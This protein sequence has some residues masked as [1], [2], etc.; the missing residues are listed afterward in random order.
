[1]GSADALPALATRPRFI[2][3]TDFDGTITQQ[4]SNDFLADHL[5]YGAER[6][7]Q[8]FNADVLEGR[9]HFRDAFHEMM[10]SIA[11]P[12]DA[13][14]ALLLDN[15]ALDPHFA[16]FYA[17]ARAAGVPVVVLSGGMR[18]IIQALLAHLLGAEAAA[19]L[20]MV[21]SDVAPRPGRASIN[22]EDGWE[23]VFHDDR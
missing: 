22:E 18:P 19:G 2:F 9:R 13:C 11:A 7:R 5:G 20:Q 14:V 23:V 4:D 12:F 6:R 21:S 17:W 15:V 8:A 10:G 16:A 3:F 1:M